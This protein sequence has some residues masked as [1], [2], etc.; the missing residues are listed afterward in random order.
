MIITLVGLKLHN[1]FHRKRRATV[2]PWS[3]SLIK[4]YPV[5]SVCF[6]RCLYLNLILQTEEVQQFEYSPSF[7]PFHQSVS[8]PLIPFASPQGSDAEDAIWIRLWK[9]DG[10]NSEIWRQTADTS[11]GAW[12]EGQVHIKADGVFEPGAYQVGSGRRKVIWKILVKLWE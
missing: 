3:F 8:R 12:Q 11:S 6:I 9:D 10:H 5:L 2:K 1:P 4:V 7:N